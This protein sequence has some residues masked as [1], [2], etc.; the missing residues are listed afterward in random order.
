VLWGAARTPPGC[1]PG[2]PLDGF[3]QS[4]MQDCSDV[5]DSTRRQAAGFAVAPSVLEE[6]GVEPVESSGVDVFPPIPETSL[7]PQKLDQTT[8]DAEPICEGPAS[9][10]THTRSGPAAGCPSEPPSLLRADEIRRGGERWHAADIDS[11]RRLGRRS[12]LER[13]G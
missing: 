11:K 5:A 1:G 13:G 2:V 12:G 7:P 8:L 3:S 9:P 6:L 4:P 10:D